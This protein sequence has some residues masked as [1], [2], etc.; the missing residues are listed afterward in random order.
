[1][2]D[3]KLYARPA[4]ALI[5]LDQSDVLATVSGNDNTIMDDPYFTD[6]GWQEC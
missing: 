6:T 4:C 1:M 2:K 5:A 3:K